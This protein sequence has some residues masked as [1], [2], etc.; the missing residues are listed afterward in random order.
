ML[1]GDLLRQL[2]GI[3]VGAAIDIAHVAY[4]ARA[5]RVTTSTRPVEFL[6]SPS[7]LTFQRRMVAKG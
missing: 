7:R 4:A 6:S 2:I 5:R 1:I 3:G